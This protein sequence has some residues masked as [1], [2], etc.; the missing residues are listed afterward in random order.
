M[1]KLSYDDI[2]AARPPKGRASEGE[3]EITPALHGKDSLGPTGIIFQ[4]RWITV[5]NDPVTFPNYSPG[6]HVR[7]IE[8]DPSKRIFG[9]VLLA[10]RPNAEG[11]FDI[12][13]V[14]QFRHPLDGWMLEIPRGGTNTGEDPIRGAVRELREETG[15]REPD[16]MLSLGEMANNSGIESTVCAYFAAVFLGH[17]KLIQREK[18]ENEAISS[19][20]W[21]PR[22]RW[23]EAIFQPPAPGRPVGPLDA[24]TFGAIGLAF[25]T[26]YLDRMKDT[27]MGMYA[28]TLAEDARVAA[29]LRERIRAG[30]YRF[31]VRIDADPRAIAHYERELPLLQAGRSPEGRSLVIRDVPLL[32]LCWIAATSLVDKISIA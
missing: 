29:P 20:V 12:A 32:T 19:V 21:I 3:V 2:L 26:G 13:F 28:G 25:M 8:G 14:R 9:V 11:D 10:V 18:S 6:T 5:V 23:R 4:N 16:L 31:T 24:F 17:Q 30:E 27:W 15:L 7:I 22:S 1:K